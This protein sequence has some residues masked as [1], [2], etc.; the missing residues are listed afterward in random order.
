M[1]GIVAVAA[2]LGTTGNIIY[3]K[4]AFELKGQ[5]YTIVDSGEVAVGMMMLLERDDAT[6]F[7]AGFTMHI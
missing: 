1:A 6:V 4:C 7:D 3:I 2:T 5:F